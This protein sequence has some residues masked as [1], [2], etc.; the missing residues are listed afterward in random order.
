MMVAWL[1][2]ACSSAPERP[3]PAPLTPLKASAAPVVVW[4]LNLP[5]GNVSP[6]VAVAPGRVYAL[7]SAGQLTALS[8]AQGQILWQHQVDGGVGSALG[9]QGDL[10]A[11]VNR[12]NELMVAGPKGVQWRQSLGTRV[13]TAPLIAGGRVFVSGLDR[14]VRAFDLNNGAALW[15]LDRQ[16]D[17]LALSEPGV[18]MPWGNTLMV[19]VAHR[20]VAVDPDK[21]QTQW[22]LALASPRGTNEIERLA[23]LVGPAARVGDVFCVRAFQSTVSCLDA[24]RRRVL[25]TRKQ[26]G[27]DAVAAGQGLV[28]GADASD[29]LTAWSLETGDTRWALDQLAHRQVTGLAVQQNWALLGDGQGFV[30][31]VDLQK[32]DLVQRLSIDASPVD[33]APL[34]VEDVAVVVTRKGTLAALRPGR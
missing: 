4:R 16:G 17:P 23:D 31:W 3:V 25:W 8:A 26:S 6:L 18:L 28:L 19:G 9:V 29:R 33:R 15:T 5:S 11:W 30:H 7:T 27:S 21:G 2:A 20:W 12:Q 22:E 32:G 14:R 10:V 13:V 24:Q 34:V 1:L